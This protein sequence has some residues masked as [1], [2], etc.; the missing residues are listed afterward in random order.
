MLPKIRRLLHGKRGIALDDQTIKVFLEQRLDRFREVPHNLGLQ[1]LDLF[2]N[3]E[4]PVLEDRIGV[5]GEDSSFHNSQI[6]I[7]TYSRN[8]AGS[9]FAYVPLASPLF[10][11]R[12]LGKVLRG[13][14]VRRPEMDFCHLLK[15][16]GP[17]LFNDL[18]G[19]SFY[20]RRYPSL[21][22]DS[23]LLPL[24]LKPSNEPLSGQN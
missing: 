13:N 11:R 24:P 6:A 9:F 3:G 12:R 8:L 7:K 10:P 23:K 22:S 19:S 4:R 5:Y 2:E 14:R 18:F 17:L 1:V 20:R 15:D 21:Q 16:V